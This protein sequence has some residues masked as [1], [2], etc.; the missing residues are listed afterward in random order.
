MFNPKSITLPALSL[1]EFDG[2]LT[3]ELVQEPAK[4]G[5]GKVP[6]STRPAAVATSIC[7]FCSTG[8]G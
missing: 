2:A 8:C 7:G 4:Y 6:A 1:R 3:S 5:L